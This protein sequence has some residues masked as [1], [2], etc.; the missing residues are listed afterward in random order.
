MNIKTIIA[1]ALAAG[2]AAGI[3]FGLLGKQDSKQDSEQSVQATASVNAV[4][5]EP[6]AVIDPNDPNRVAEG[7]PIE[8]ATRAPATVPTQ[9]P[10]FDSRV[11]NQAKPAAKATEPTMT[12][13]QADAVIATKEAQMQ[14]MIT[15]YNA[16]LNDPKAKAA[17]ERKFK[18]QSQEYKKALL[19]KVKNGEL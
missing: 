11:L 1:I 3:G 9:A 2:A 5:R 7:A 15:N 6:V 8:T 4:T 10:D 19:A 14:Q 16:A 17:L 12:S 18:I 13:A